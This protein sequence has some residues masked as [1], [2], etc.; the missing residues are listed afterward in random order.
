MNWVGYARRG[1][2]QDTRDELTASGITAHAPVTLVLERRGNDRRPRAYVEPVIPRLLF[3]RGTAHDFHRLHDVRTLSR[4]L[5]AFPDASW[6]AYV[7]PFLARCAA[8]YDAMDARI[9]AGEMLDEYK[10]GDRLAIK[11]GPFADQ[12]ASFLRVVER[13][14]DLHPMLV[15][16]MEVFGGVREIEVDPLAVKR[17]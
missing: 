4:T 13:A 11:A 2:E 6:N 15:A 3:I 5:M 16:E 17:A 9:K 14:H 1:A 12:V 10:R 7:A 8:E